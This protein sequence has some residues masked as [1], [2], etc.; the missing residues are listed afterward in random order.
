MWCGLDPFV[1]W[2]CLPSTPTS[3]WGAG[4][5]DLDGLD[6]EVDATWCPDAAMSDGGVVPW[7][8]GSVPL[9]G[10]VVQPDGAVPRPGDDGAVPIGDGAIAD[11]NRPG[12]GA[13]PVSAPPG[14]SFRGGGGCVCRASPGRPLPE[15]WLAAWLA[16]AVGWGA[17]TR[18]R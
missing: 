7:P 15:A 12:D 6:N 8:D 13:P 9:D 11:A 1:V 16:I 18:R 10:S 3:D 2:Q 17:H 5:C 4:N 14:V